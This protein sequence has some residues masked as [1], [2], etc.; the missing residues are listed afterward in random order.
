LRSIAGAAGGAVPTVLEGHERFSGW[1][2]EARGIAAD[3]ESDLAGGGGSDSAAV[4]SISSEAKAALK[5]VSGGGKPA[6]PPPGPPPGGGGGGARPPSSSK[7]STSTTSSSAAQPDPADTNGDG[8][9]SAAEKAI[10]ALT[11]SASAVSSS[12]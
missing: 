2:R 6:G 3:L 9:V 11:Q 5:A 4:V 8:T 1:R 12:E 7:E 10:Y